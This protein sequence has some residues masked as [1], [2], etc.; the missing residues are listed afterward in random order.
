MSTQVMTKR[1]GALRRTVRV[2]DTALAPHGLDRYVELAW[3]TWSTTEIRARVVAAKRPTADCVTLTL[4]PNGNWDGFVAGQHTQLTVEIDGVRYTRC[5]SMANAAPGSGR[6]GALI[7]LT[8]KAHP[9]GLVSRYLVDNAAP[10]MVVGLS[11]AQGDFTLPDPRPS[12]ILLISGGSGIT[13]V[14]SMLRTLCAEGHP[15]AVTFVHYALTAEDHPYREEVERLAA[16]HQNV[17]VVNVYTDAPGTGDLDGFFNPT[18]LQEAEPEWDQTE[19]FVCGPAPLM[20]A[21]RSHF[22]EAGLASRYHDEAF[23][24]APLEA[25]PTG[26]VIELASS[27]LRLV[28]AGGSI[29]EQAEANGLRPAHGC[30]MGICHSCTRPMTSGAVRDL[31]T[32]E[33][34]DR[35]GDIRICVSAPASDVTIDL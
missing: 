27:D 29:L 9:E 21:V 17:R 5:Y 28:D 35:P 1:R 22:A 30:R 3:P 33:V 24:L 18:Q 16:A 23:V 26:A 20:D 6:A 8:V 7:E 12:R 10:G 19:A 2:L 25:R 4:R 14:M 15:G 13:P 31:V 11:P 34:I 32:G